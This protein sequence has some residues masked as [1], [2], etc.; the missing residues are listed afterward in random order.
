MT[1]RKKTMTLH[2]KPQSEQQEP[3]IKLGVNSGNQQG[4]AVPV[5]YVAPIVLLLL[6]TRR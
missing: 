1:K 6:P 4:Y 5:K 2:R 3:Y